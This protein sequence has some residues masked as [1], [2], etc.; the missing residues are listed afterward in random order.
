MIQTLIKK[1]STNTKMNKYYYMKKAIDIAEQGRGRTSPNPFVGAIIVSKGRVVGRGFT[2]PAGQNHAEVEA[3]LD[4]GDKCKGGYIYVTLEPCCHYGKTPPCTN[5]IISSGIERVFIGIEDPDYKVAGKG[6]DILREAGLKV[7][8]GLYDEEIRKQLEAYIFSRQNTGLYVHSKIAASMD[9]KTALDNGKSKWITNEESRKRVHAMRNRSDVLITGIN[10]VLADN[11]MLNVRGIE[12]SSNPVRAILD[13]NLRIPVD[14]NIVQT[15][16]EQKTIVFYVEGKPEKVEVLEENGVECIMVAMEYG[17]VNL[18]QM[19][20][21]L[22]NKGYM[23]LMLEAGRTLNTA[24]LQRGLLNRI[25]YFI[26]GKILGGEH[27][28]FGGFK[29]DEV[30][31]AVKLSVEEVCTLDNDVLIEYRVK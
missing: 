4:A 30:D 20:G 27:S 26:G 23:L 9:G 7:E 31:Q 13:T 5:A 18:E 24:F 15:A 14:C 12:N 8:V 25:S 3:I 19:T 21:I 1:M 11:P 10:T 29:I 22:K 6:I 16:E 17:H 28:I 2:Q